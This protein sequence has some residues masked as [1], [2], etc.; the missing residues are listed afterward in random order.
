MLSEASPMGNREDNGT[1]DALVGT[2]LPAP[3]HIHQDELMRKQECQS[4]V[5]LK[6]DGFPSLPTAL[7]RQSHDGFRVL[8]SEHRCKRLLAGVESLL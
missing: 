6:D 5:R 1:R 8:H 7:S 2:G 3:C 4:D